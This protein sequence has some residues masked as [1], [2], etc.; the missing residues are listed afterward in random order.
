ME[1]EKA[2]K[3][4]G[5][6]KA[7]KATAEEDGGAIKEEKKAVKAKG[8]IMVGN[9]IAVQDIAAIKVK[10]LHAVKKERLIQS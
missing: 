2:V 8:A 6:I 7:K 10:K 4:G 1:T 3:A 5:A 9:K